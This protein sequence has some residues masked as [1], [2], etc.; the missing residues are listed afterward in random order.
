M[1]IAGK[2]FL[3]YGMGVSGQS[4]Y[5]F[6]NKHNANVFL[7]SDKNTKST[8]NRNAIKKFSD[9]LK[10]KYDYVVL[11]PGIQIIGNKN[12][13]KLKQNGAILISEI[14]LGYLFCKGKFIA[15]TGTNGKTTC[16]SL[17]NHVLSK[18][19]KTFLC[20]NIG[21]PIT[22][23][24][25]KTDENSIVICE[26]SSFML[27]I[28]SQNFTPDI[29]GILNITPDHI[30]RHKTF[31]N[32]YKTKLKITQ[33]QRENQYF[34]T[35]N[36]LKNISTNAKKI[37][38]NNNKKYKS[39]L[40]GE[41]NQKNIA[42]C[43]KTCEL[44]SVNNKEFKKHLNTFYPIKYRL[45][46][47]KKIKGVSYINDSKST[48][49]DSC[50]KALKSMKKPVV[51]LLGGSD[52]GNDYYDIFAF[53]KNIRLAIIYGQTANKLEQD[54][55][56][57]GFY[58]IVKFENLCSALYHLKE[59]LKKRDVVLFSPA[60]ASYDEFKNYVERGEYFNNFI[61]KKD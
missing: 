24:C 28:I 53:S 33:F 55:H 16:V 2:N 41:F 30:S 14:E 31:D 3:V 15:I 45:E 25:D 57:M 9:V 54:A 5:E 56:F 18:K 47:V 27:E 52:K 8:E 21:I 40:I 12:I 44:L 49:P 46:F 51:L 59:Y 43:E 7:Y 34:L 6:L 35:F 61:S 1:E 32:Y 58:N 29:A 42:F 38:I 39:N 36:S 37:I 11:S 22:S 20:G 48:N 4:A 26:V 19:Y 50:I 13:K 10:Q 17:L 60:C 23:I